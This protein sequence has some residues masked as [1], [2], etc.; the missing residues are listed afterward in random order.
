M[1]QKTVEK[2]LESHNFAWSEWHGC[3]DIAARRKEMLLL[4]VLDNVD[5]FQEQQALNLS[6]L[7]GS[8]DAFASVIGT[9]TRYEELNDNVIYERFSVPA[10]TPETLDS[11]LSSETPFLYRAR[12]GMFSDVDP[13]ALHK[14]REKAGL[15]Q[16]QLA[17]AVGVSKKNIYEHERMQ[18]KA[19]SEV[20]ERIEKELGAQITL[21]FVPASL[22]SET[23]VKSEDA[24]EISVAKELR[25]IGFEAG[26]VRQSPF[27]IIAK[28]KFLIISEAGSDVRKLRKKLPHLAEFSEVSR[29]PTLV[30]TEKELDADLPV[31]ERRHLKEMSAKELRKIARK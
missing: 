4:K 31:V 24:F 14:A 10:F 22:K 27:N 5:S 1:L 11:I 9:H 6:T 2:I 15:S 25:R 13:K 8:L 16:S 17:G 30:I 18:K 7:S 20:V 26:F 29:K 12:G 3:F 19:R 23:T 21:P 28:E